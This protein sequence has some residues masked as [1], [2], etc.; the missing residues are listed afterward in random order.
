MVMDGCIVGVMGRFLLTWALCCIVSWEDE[1]RWVIS[2]L[3][4]EPEL[5][6]WA[7]QQIMN[8]LSSELDLNSHSFLSF[9]HSL[10]FLSLRYCRM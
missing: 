1:R 2:R 9:Y 3:E 6:Y 5:E 10:R 7:I 8:D 4:L